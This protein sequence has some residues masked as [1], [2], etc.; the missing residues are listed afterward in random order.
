VCAASTTRHAL[1][2]RPT[3]RTTESNLD[4]QTPHTSFTTNAT[5]GRPARQVFNADPMNVVRDLVMQLNGGQMMV[6]AR[7]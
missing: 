3:T 1:T 6:Q 5:T 4:N 7:A 2:V